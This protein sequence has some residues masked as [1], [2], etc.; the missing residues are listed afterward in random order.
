M[1]EQYE[2]F[3]VGDKVKILPYATS[4][5]VEDE[6]IGKIG[7]IRSISSRITDWSGFMVAMEEICDVRGYAPCWS[8]GWRMIELFPRKNEQLIFDFMR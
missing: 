2:K 1:A 8:V 7:T 4:V 6:E 5:G 3:R